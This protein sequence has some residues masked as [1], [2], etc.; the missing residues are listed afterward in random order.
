[1]NRGR[2][3][4]IHMMRQSCFRAAWLPAVFLFLNCLF[5]AIASGNGGPLSDRLLSNPSPVPSGIRTEAE[6]AGHLAVIRIGGNV[7]L[8]LQI[9][10][11]R[12]GL[13]SVQ[14][15]QSDV[16]RPETFFLRESVPNCPFRVESSGQSC[17]FQLFP[18]SFLPVRAGP[19]SLCRFVFP[20]GQRVC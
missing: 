17:L 2:S 16:S 5:S 12:P 13:S 6:R 1:M 10:N 18:R 7:G 19:V 20:G 8:Q 3:Q 4:A 15:L 14:R 9:R 11:G